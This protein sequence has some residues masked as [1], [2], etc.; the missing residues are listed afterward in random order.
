MK[1][2]KSESIPLDGLQGNSPSSRNNP[3]RMS[4]GRDASAVRALS[5]YKKPTV[6]G[7]KDETIF[8]KNVMH[9]VRRNGQTRR[10]DGRKKSEKKKRKMCQMADAAAAKCGSDE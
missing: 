3:S 9:T 5:R 2:K 7:S 6:C 4:A 8:S 1:N 10:T